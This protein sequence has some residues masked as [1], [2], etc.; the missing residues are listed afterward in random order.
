MSDTSIFNVR[1]RGKAAAAVEARIL[2]FPERKR[3]WPIVQIPLT[4]QGNEGASEF[5]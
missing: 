4:L 5:R 2:H 3:M 1:M